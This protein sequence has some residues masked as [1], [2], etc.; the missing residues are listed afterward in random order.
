MLHPIWM[1]RFERDLT[2]IFALKDEVTVAVVSAIQPKLFKAGLALATRRRL[3]NT[4]L[5]ESELSA[6]SARH[7]RVQLSTTVRMR[8][9]RPS[10]SWFLVVDQIALPLEQ[11]MQASIAEATAHLRLISVPLA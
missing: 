6:T 8:K 4:L 5:P 3:E 2:D 1:H 11:N 7:S 9:R 10:V